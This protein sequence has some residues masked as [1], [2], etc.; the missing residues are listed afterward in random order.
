MLGWWKK[1]ITDGKK[2]IFP[3]GWKKINNGWKKMGAKNIY[4]AT[5][6]YIAPT[7][8]ESGW[9]SFDRACGMLHRLSNVHW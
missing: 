9:F 5:K 2:V 7:K 3:N 8:N 1:I 4:C 6:K